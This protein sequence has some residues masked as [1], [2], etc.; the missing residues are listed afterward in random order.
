MV[1][2]K[3]ESDSLDKKE[4]QESCDSSASDHSQNISGGE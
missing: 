3:E 1:G 4:A 2:S